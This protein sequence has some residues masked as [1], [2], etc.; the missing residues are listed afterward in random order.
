MTLPISGA[1]F[2]P[3]HI[4]LLAKHP[5]VPHAVIDV[6]D[7][8]VTC[9]YSRCAAG[10]DDVNVTD[11]SSRRR[12]K[13]VHKWGRVKW[14]CGPWGPVRPSWRSFALLQ[15]S[16][17]VLRGLLRSALQYLVLPVLLCA[18]KLMGR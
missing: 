5:A 10:D 18:Q 7:S 13:S 2:R 11:N 9:D 8:T 12:I 3:D 16:F 14:P 6:N 15:Q 17:S 1:T 4:V